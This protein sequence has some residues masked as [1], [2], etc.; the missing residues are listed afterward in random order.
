MTRPLD[1]D[2]VRSAY[3]AE[4]R[5][6]PPVDAGFRLDRRPTIVRLIGPVRSFVLYSRPAM[7][8]VSAMVEEEVRDQRVR[9][10]EL[11][12]KVY[13]HDRPANLSEVLAGRGFRPEP[14]ETRLPLPCDPEGERGPPGG[15]GAI[16]SRRI[17][18]LA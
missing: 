12:W 8:E 1:V 15:W 10:G 6:D 11:E 3:D 4:M 2:A 7:S 16:R 9:G 17:L 5:V 14:S 18:R 13:S